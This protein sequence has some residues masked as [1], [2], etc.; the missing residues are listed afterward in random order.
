MLAGIQDCRTCVLVSLEALSAELKHDVAELL[1]VAR[2]SH[3]CQD[4][5]HGMLRELDASEL[6]LVEDLEGSGGVIAVKE[7]RDHARKDIL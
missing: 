2:L 3:C 4:S 7:H 5:I 1:Q 6:S